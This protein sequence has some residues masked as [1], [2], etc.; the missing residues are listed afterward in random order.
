MGGGDS[1]AIGGN[2][3]GDGVTIKTMLVFGE[4]QAT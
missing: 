2:P 3:S 1:L 4:G